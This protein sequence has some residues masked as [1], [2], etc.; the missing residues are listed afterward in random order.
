VL[1]RSLPFTDYYKV[2]GIDHTADVDAVKRAFRKMALKYHPDKNL[3]PDAKILFPKVC[4]SYDV[5]SNAQRRA[6]YDQYGPHGLANGVP[7]RPDFEGFEGGYKFH[8][9]S[10]LVFSQF[11][12]GKNPFADFFAVH[13]DAVS[14][15]GAK[16][17]GLHGMTTGNAASG[18]PVQ[19]PPIEQDLHLTFEELYNG[20]IKKI[21]ITRRVFKEDGPSTVE[22]DKILVIDVKK[23]WKDGT[24]LT[25]PQEGDQGPNQIPADIVFTVREVPH[26]RF[27]R[28]GNDLIYESK[29]ILKKALM[30]F[31]L[32][33]EMLDGR[34]LKIPVHEIVHDGFTKEV[35]Q[36]GMPISKS[37]EQ[38]GKLILKFGVEFPTYLSKTQKEL[39][40]K[41]L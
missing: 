32:D 7:S 14:P 35:A 10:E 5:L 27:K 17:G 29:I 16:F 8:G 13:N 1:F 22:A 38:R 40:S 37:P 3:S 19:P 2:L 21:K 9:D 11:F 31:I 26:S 12:G 39:I 20:T 15:F 6:V 30:G 28:D 41:A 36:E 23:G 4:E 34:L 33:L 25:F 18:E 24:R